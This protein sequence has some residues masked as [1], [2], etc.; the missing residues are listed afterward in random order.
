MLISGNVEIIDKEY[1]DNLYLKNIWSKFRKGDRIFEA[2]ISDIGP[3]GQ[4]VTEEH[5]GIFAEH[6][7]GDIDYLQT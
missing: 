4:L 7:F 3:F 5:S 2:R 1:L 6:M